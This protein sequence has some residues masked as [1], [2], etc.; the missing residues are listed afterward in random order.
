MGEGK[1]SCRRAPLDKGARGVHNGH[2]HLLE[3]L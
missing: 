1:R 3:G 2:F